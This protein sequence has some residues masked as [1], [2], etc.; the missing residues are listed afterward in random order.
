VNFIIKT[1]MT[2][3]SGSLQ[4]RR[5]EAK[6]ITNK[7]YQAKYDICIIENLCKGSMYD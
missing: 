7:P 6:L 5:L 3:M 1:K 4:W 2:L